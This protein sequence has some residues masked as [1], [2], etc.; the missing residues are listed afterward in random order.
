MVRRTT[1]TS[2]SSIIAHCFTIHFLKFR[3][4]IPNASF[5]SSC[6]NSERWSKM[7]FILST[8]CWAS[9]GF[10]A[11]A[12]GH[13]SSFSLSKSIT[14]GAS[15]KA[16]SNHDV[17]DTKPKEGGNLVGTSKTRFR[18]VFLVGTAAYIGSKT[19]SACRALANF[20]HQPITIQYSLTM[21]DF[22]ARWVELR[23]QIK[24]KSPAGTTCWYSAHAAVGRNLVESSEMM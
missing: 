6:I 24:G 22:L 15:F 17:L 5:L 2:A 3:M 7:L 16:F 8:Y 10:C 4:V 13:S 18:M 19:Q 9:S 11:P 1:S 20:L 14:G 21:I 23:V 12:S